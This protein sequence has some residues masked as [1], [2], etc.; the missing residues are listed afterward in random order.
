MTINDGF[1]HRGPFENHSLDAKP[2]HALASCGRLCL[3]G[4]AELRK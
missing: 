1:F 3:T 4:D 2:V